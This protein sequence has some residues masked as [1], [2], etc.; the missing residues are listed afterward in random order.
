MLREAIKDGHIKDPFG[1]V[2]LA[3]VTNKNDATVL[4]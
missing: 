3:E 1:L 4:E 2:K